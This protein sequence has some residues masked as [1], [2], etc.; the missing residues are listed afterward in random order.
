[1]SNEYVVN[2]NNTQFLWICTKQNPVGNLF[3]DRFHCNMSVRSTTN[4]NSG[5]SSPH[6]ILKSPATAAMPVSAWR[7]RRRQRWRAKDHSELAAQHAYLVHPTL[8]DI[9]MDGVSD[10]VNVSSI[11]FWPTWWL[12]PDS[13]SGGVNVTLH[14]CRRWDIRQGITIIISSVVFLRRLFTGTC[15]WHGHFSG[16]S[17][18]CCFHCVC[19]HHITMS[20]G[21]HNIIVWLFGLR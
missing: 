18:S 6:G 13:A 15:H 12:S 14:L 19:P 4:L 2:M 21:T 16:L 20:D 8:A 3:K 17:Y 1:M 10:D 9:F 7:R 11:S 5:S